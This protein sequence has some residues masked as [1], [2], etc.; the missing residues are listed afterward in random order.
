MKDELKGVLLMIGS[1]LSFAIMAMLIKMVSDINSVT[2]VFFRFSVSIGI[3]SLLALTKVIKLNF[4]RSPLLLLRGLTGGIATYLFYLSIV[5]LGMGK[6]T[7]YVYSYPIFA[8]IFSVIFLREK[9]SIRIWILIITAFI[10]IYIL[11]LGKGGFRFFS[12]NLYELLAITSSI[13]SAFSITIVKKLHATD[14]TY[15]IFFA[16]ATVGFWIFI[17]PAN[18]IAVD[19]SNWQFSLLIIAGVTAVVGQLIMTEGYRYIPVSLGTSLHM[20]VPVLSLI[21]AYLFFNETLNAIELLGTGI[22]ILVCIVLP[23]LQSRNT[24]NKKAI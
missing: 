22:V 15:A 7:V 5:K 12:F 4:I 3:M 9:V 18:T 11:S 19:I 14:S 17:F 16:Q 24:G 1:V 13:F 2:T 20:M 23:F 8:T 10:G 6:G 21:I